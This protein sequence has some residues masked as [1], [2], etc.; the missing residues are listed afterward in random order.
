MELSGQ[1]GG[2]QAVAALLEK[3]GLP[4]DG[5][6]RQQLLPDGGHACFHIALR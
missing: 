3:V 6:D 1:T 5:A 4:S 2:Q